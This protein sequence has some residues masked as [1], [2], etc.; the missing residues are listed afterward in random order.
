LQFPCQEDFSI[1]T[2]TPTRAVVADDDDD[3]DAGDDAPSDSPTP[4]STPEDN[5]DGELSNEGFEEEEPSNEGFDMD[6][7]Q[8]QGGDPIVGIPIGDD[9]DNTVGTD[10]GEVSNDEDFPST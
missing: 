4:A 10:D 3:D 7:S 8:F 6:R 9:D 2:G 5:D 1:P